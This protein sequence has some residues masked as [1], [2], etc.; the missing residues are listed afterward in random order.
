MVF[1]YRG[2]AIKEENEFNSMCSKALVEVLYVV[3]VALPLTP[4][5]PVEFAIQ[6]AQA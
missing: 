1:P 5:Y 3:N 4:T 2:V 6:F